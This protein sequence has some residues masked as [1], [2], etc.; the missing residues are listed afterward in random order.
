MK[1]DFSSSRKSA[2]REG[3]I[4]GG[5]FYKLKEGAN[6]IRL[7]SECL[8]HPG[9]YKGTKTFKWL[10]HI[11]DRNDGEVKV[12]FMAHTIYSQIEALQQTDDYAFDSVPMP[13]DITINAKGAGTKEV[14]YTVI[15]ARANKPL[16]A[17]EEA[18]FAAKKPIEEVR[19]AMRAKNDDQPEEHTSDAPAF[20]PDNVPF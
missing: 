18:L 20:D 13:Y 9:E 7:L 2:E 6:P 15:A 11:L 17:A 5:D 16:T 3:Y 14:K 8:P 1:V 19:A 4:T 10:C 12:F